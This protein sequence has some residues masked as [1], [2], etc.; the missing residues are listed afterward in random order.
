VTTRAS[1]NRVSGERGVTSSQ[2][3]SPTHAPVQSLP[4]VVRLAADTTLLILLDRETPQSDGSVIFHGTL[5][6]PVSQ[7]GAIVLMEKTEVI[8]FTM[9]SSGKLSIYIEDVIVQGTT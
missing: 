4:A 3:R 9:L 8:G 7:S 2:Q 5:I 6:Y 1:A